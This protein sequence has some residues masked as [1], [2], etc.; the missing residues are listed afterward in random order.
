[1]VYL[2]LPGV[3]GS[4]F[5]IIYERARVSNFDLADKIGTPFEL[6]D[7][8]LPKGTWYQAVLF[9]SVPGIH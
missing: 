9:L 5:S 7:V 1:M 8:M 2:S 6:P 4:G 3:P